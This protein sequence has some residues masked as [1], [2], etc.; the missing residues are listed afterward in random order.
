MKNLRVREKKR[1]S[2][3]PLDC[4][5]DRV[6]LEASLRLL[7]SKGF[8]AFT[9]EEVAKKARA[10]KGSI[11]RRWKSKEELIAA[12]LEAV[13]AH[14]SQEV[15]EVLDDLSLDLKRL[16]NF[17]FRPKDLRHQDLLI[18]VFSAGKSNPL[19]TSDVRA[20]FEREQRLSILEAFR[21]AALRGEVRSEVDLET[22]SEIPVSLLLYRLLLRGERVTEAKIDE[23]VD[24]VVIPITQA[25]K[26][27]SAGRAPRA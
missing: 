7:L 12:A 6:I 20:L 11:Y 10:G 16:L 4:G 24:E 13:F 14:H 5:K 3:R 15:A 26:T 25:G 21:R 18:A 19:I 1:C 22:L 2:G 17:H 23:I 8:H 9:V 27:A